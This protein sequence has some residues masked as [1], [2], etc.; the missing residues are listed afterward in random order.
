MPD[1]FDFLRV[2]DAQQHDGRVAG[3]AVAPKT[4]LSAPVVEQHAV[5]CAARRI[6]I[7]QRARE[8][9]VELRL[10]LGDVELVQR[11]LAVRPSEIKDA[12]GHAGALIFFDVRERG[13][14]V[15]GHAQNQVNDGGAKRRQR[16]RAPQGNDG[17]EHGTDGVGQR[18]NGLHRRRIGEAAAAAD[19]AG[20]IRFAGDFALAIAL[21]LHQ[22]QQPRRLFMLQTGRGACREW[23]KICGRIPFARRDC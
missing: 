21:N 19:K 15:F 4:I 1:D 5:V 22:M 13:F 12:V 14:A 8:P 3:N 17:I 7:N 11:H 20:T 10:R 16:D 18:R 6:G 9:A 2:A 23:R